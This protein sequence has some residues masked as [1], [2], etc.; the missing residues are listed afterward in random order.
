MT[1]SDDVLGPLAL[2]QQPLMRPVHVI[3]LSVELVLRRT[4]VVEYE[5]TEPRRPGD[6]P[7]CLSIGVHREDDRA[8]GMAVQQHVLRVGA[9]RDAPQRRH[10]VRVHL[11]VA[12]SLGFAGG[13]MQALIDVPSRR[14]VQVRLRCPFSDG[15]V[16]L[17]QLL[18]L[19]D[20]HRHPP[21]RH[22]RTMRYEWSRTSAL[23]SMLVWPL[24]RHPS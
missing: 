1:A 19:L 15:C 7:G 14:Q 11:R 9:L 16:S 2:S 22:A 13:R 6:V 17:R 23:I 24:T 8:P 10:A 12:D 4:T 20:G 21:V 3:G 5:G 18:R